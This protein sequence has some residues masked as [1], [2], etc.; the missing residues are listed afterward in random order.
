M[1][2]FKCFQWR[3]YVEASKAVNPAVEAQINTWV[4]MWKE[5]EQTNPEDVLTTCQEA[6]AVT[7]LLCCNEQD[8]QY[9]TKI[10]T[11]NRRSFQN[12]KIH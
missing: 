2:S 10:Y 4:S 7:N 5:R 12:R 11:G 8:N 9:D 3:E 6:E 1:S